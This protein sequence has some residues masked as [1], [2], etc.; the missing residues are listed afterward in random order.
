MD[1]HWR[2]TALATCFAVLALA[3]AT[4]AALPKFS[5]KEIVINKSLAGV[6]LGGSPESGQKAWGK[7]GAECTISGCSW[8]VGRDD[9]VANFGF[10]EGKIVG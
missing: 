5:D 10:V 8:A 1:S 7:K 9:G 2:I 3:P 6:K 4:E